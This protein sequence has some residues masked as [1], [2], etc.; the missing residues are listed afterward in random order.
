MSNG[1]RDGA[2]DMDTDFQS[3]RALSLWAPIL[4]G[5]MGNPRRRRRLRRFELDEEDGEISD[6]EARRGGD[7]DLDREL[8][9]I[10]R[11]RRRSSATILQLLQGIRDGMASETENPDNDRDTFIVAAFGGKRPQQIR[12]SSSTKRGDRGHA[13]CQNQG[14]FAMFCVLR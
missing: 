1:S 7:T 9:S 8:E 12:N 14:E 13:D 10:I 4:L 2:Q 11:S 3:D 5:M 6:G